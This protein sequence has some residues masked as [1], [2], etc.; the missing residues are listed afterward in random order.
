[1]EG[2]VLTEEEAVKLAKFFVKFIAGPSRS[3]HSISWNGPGKPIW[4]R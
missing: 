1:M 3:N 2:N 4:A